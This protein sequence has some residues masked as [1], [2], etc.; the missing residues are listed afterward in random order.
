MENGRPTGT[1]IM[2]QRRSEPRTSQQLAVRV[3]GLDSA[4]RPISQPSYSLDI[5]KRGARL[6][7]LPHWSA[8]GETI[9][10]R[11]GAE[12]ARF[13][14]VWTGARGTPREGE[15]G[16]LCLEACRV[17][18]GMMHPVPEAR[19]MA[20]AAVP[21]S[22]GPQTGVLGTSILGRRYNR[23]GS[24]RYRCGGGA[25]IQEIGASAGQWTM[26]QDISLHGCYVQTTS[27][28]PAGT[29]VGATVLVGDVKIATLGQITETDRMV[30]MGVRFT[31]MTP[32]NRQGLQAL[33]EQLMQSGAREA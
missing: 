13:R 17:I 7:G 22:G 23:R 20:A 28:L 25:K 19:T 8:P 14:V 5:S 29:L 12:K 10:V 6:M 26:M 18:W 3:F 27:P 21:L 31:E 4:G 15:V 32:L 1:P 24:G 9:G 2:M 11:C 30:G 33:L 16:L